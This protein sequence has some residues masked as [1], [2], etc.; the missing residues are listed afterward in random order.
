LASQSYD[1]S[2]SKYVQKQGEKW[3]NQF[4]DFTE[5]Q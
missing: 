4:K 5:K 2:F 3:W 1:A